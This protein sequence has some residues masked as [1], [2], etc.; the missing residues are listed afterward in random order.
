M[1]VC[2]A[3][4]RF[5]H[6]QDFA[7]RKLY[8]LIGIYL[9]RCLQNVCNTPRSRLRVCAADPVAF[10]RGNYLSRLTAISTTFRLT[11]VKYLPQCCRNFD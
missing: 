4:F 7:C 6:T 10:G 11:V 2:V 1:T 8:K 9:V 3:M 5:F